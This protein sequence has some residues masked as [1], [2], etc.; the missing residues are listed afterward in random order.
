MR[1]AEIWRYLGE[2]VRFYALEGTAYRTIERS[3]ILSPM[4][5]SQATIF[6]ELSRQATAA[7]W[8]RAVREWIRGTPRY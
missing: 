1:V 8:D 5:A 3:V 4:T 6:L 7:D 2:R